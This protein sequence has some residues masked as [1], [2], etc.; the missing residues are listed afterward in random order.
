M[1][2]YVEFVYVFHCIVY[3]CSCMLSGFYLNIYINKRKL[4]VLVMVVNLI[5]VGLYNYM[6]VFTALLLDLLILLQFCRKLSLF[7]G[8]LVIRFSI[9]ISMYFLFGG[10][11]YYGIWFMKTSSYQWIFVGGVLIMYTYILLYR[12][13]AFSKTLEYC[14]KISIEFSN[15]HVCCYG[16]WDSGNFANEKGIPII[17]LH[18]DRIKMCNL[19]NVLVDNY[20]IEAVLGTVTGIHIPK[21]KVYIAYL[22]HEIIHMYPCLLNQLLER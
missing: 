19:E 9:V 15:C 11:V 13:S 20:Q 6:N 16:Y 17:F 14:Y 12:Y 22:N 4:I 1:K 10:S 5:F 8:I 7:F 18:D 21:Q 2:S 3:I